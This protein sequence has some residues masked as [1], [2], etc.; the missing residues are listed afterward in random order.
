MLANFDDITLQGGN[1]YYAQ[2]IE[3]L[4]RL[5]H[6]DFAAIGMAAFSGAPLRW[7]YSYGAT[8]DKYRRIALTPGHGIGGIVLK[9]GKPMVTTDIDREMDPSEYSGYPIVFAED[10]QS[11]AAFPLLRNEQ[12]VGVLLL[13]FRTSS[14]EHLMTFKQCVEGLNGEFCGL[15]VRSEDALSFDEILENERVADADAF[16]GDST[17]ARI[18]SAQEEERRRISREVHDGVTQE[19]LSVAL[20]LN[21]ISLLAQ[22]DEEREIV[23]TA[24]ARLQTVMSQLHDLSV[25]LRPS[26]LDHFGLVAALRSQAEVLEN[27]Y[28]NRIV[29]T[30][31]LGDRRFSPAYETQVYRI[32]Q[33]AVTNACKY[34]DCDEVRV[35][36]DYDGD[37]LHVEVHDAGSGFDVEHPEIK[38][39][40][41]GLT[42]M[43]ERA[44]LIGAKLDVASGDGGT[45]V[46]LVSPIGALGQERTGEG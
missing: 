16:V 19:I 20:Q 25:E 14:S 12:V 23:Q 9:A 46:T 10:L 27:T 5:F 41:C 44:R 29:I 45:T 31:T 22:S 7:V 26:V 32:T 21:K 28:G 4:G 43:A 36:V 13:A 42:G 2:A 30:G 11:F 18:I 38:G 1:M 39:S 34:A 37:W 24:R 6:F 8:N 17:V 40:G 15:A 3:D 33:E 35:R